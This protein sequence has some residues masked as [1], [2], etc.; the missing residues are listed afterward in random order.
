MKNMFKIDYVEATV[1]YDA[2]NRDNHICLKPVYQLLRCS[3]GTKKRQLRGYLPCF[4]IFRFYSDVCPH[5]ASKNGIK[6][7]KNQ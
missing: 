2:T 7:I 5:L 1:H 3:L 6:S 4:R